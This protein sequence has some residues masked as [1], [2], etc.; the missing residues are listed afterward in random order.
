MGNNRDIYVGTTKLDRGSQAYR[1]QA[2]E[3]K[4]RCKA[5]NAGCHICNGELGPIDYLAEPGTSRAF[6]ID[7]VLPTAIRPDLFLTVSNWAPSHCSCNRSRQ[8]KDMK[9]VRTHNSKPG[10]WVRPSW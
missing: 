3:F 10:R 1:K 5:V 4:A 2:R 7:H 9:E 6:E 8:A